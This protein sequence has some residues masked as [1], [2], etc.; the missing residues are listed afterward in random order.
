VKRPALPP[1]TS[2]A[3]LS[4]PQRTTQYSLSAAEAVLKKM[5]PDGV[6]QAGPSM[7]ISNLT[8]RL[9]GA[10]GWRIEIAPLLKRVF[11]KNSNT[12]LT[13]DNLRFERLPGDP[14]AAASAPLAKGHQGLTPAERAAMQVIYA[15]LFIP[16]RGL[17]LNQPKPTRTSVARFKGGEVLIQTEDQLSVDDQE[18]AVTARRCHSLVVKAPKGAVVLYGKGEPVTLNGQFIVEDEGELVLPS[19]HLSLW[20]LRILAPPDPTGVLSPKLLCSAAVEVPG[21]GEKSIAE[22]AARARRGRRP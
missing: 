4:A 19:P 5:F 15:A 17:E 21:D 10:T 11:K 13:P 9:N 1:L 18:S 20:T 14:Y 16:V 8:H 6:V 22:S 7:S 2:K 12:V 3:K